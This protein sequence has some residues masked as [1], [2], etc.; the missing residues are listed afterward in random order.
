MHSIRRPE[1]F[2]GQLDGANGVPLIN[3]G[4]W[5]LTFGN[6]GNGGS[7]SDLNFTAGIPGPG[8]V[9]GHGLFGSIA[10]TPEPGTLTLIGTGLLRLI[11]YRR[12][13]TNSI[14]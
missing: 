3:L 4:R 12:R 14:A 9:E 11:A 10:P 1:D 2:L 5:G 13:R 7:M 6:G 8:A